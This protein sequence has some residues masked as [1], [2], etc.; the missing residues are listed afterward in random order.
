MALDT[1]SAKERE[2][3][4]EPCHEE[5]CRKSRNSAP[6]SRPDVTSLEDRT[7]PEQSPDRT[8]ELI[9]AAS[10]TVREIARVVARLEE[11]PTN[12]ALQAEYD[13]LQGVLG[14]SNDALS[15]ISRQAVESLKAEYGVDDEWL[16]A[17]DQAQRPALG[18]DYWSSTIQR[19]PTTAKLEEAVAYGYE[20]LKAVVDQ[21][22]L[23][24]QAAFRYRQRYDGSDS[25]DC[26]LHVVGRQRLLPPNA[27]ARPQR[28]AQMLLLCEDLLSNRDDIDLFEGPLLVSEAA[29][30]GACLPAIDHLGREAKAKFKSLPTETSRDVASIV[31]ELLVG[32]A[33]VEIGRTVEM[34]PASNRHKSPDFRIHDLPVPLVVEC[35]RRLGLNDYAEK[36]ARHVERLYSAAEELF[37]RC[38][39]LVEVIFNGEVS[40]VTEESFVKAVAPLCE[41]WDSEAE[42]VTSWGTIHV[43]RLPNVQEIPTTRVFS[44]VFLQEVF[45]WDHAESNWDGLLC[46]IAPT[47]SPVTD[48]VRCPRGLKW[49]CDA[50]KSL[51]KKARGLTSLWAD[52]VRQ[53]PAGE[54]GCVY[55]AYTESMRGAIADARTQHLLDTVQNKELYHR[56]SVRVPLT[57]ID[58]LYP[59]ALGNGGLEL[60]E[61]I[62]P[63]TLDGY[64][65]MLEDFPLQA[66]NVTP[67]E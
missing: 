9:Q 29:R 55:I 24:D 18:D 6:T 13:R 38:H 56:A 34:L 36:E 14:K 67:L 32:T 15:E 57:V 53:I 40:T 20:R 49:R 27:P 22:W 63:M 33:C 46:Q 45:Y 1:C 30:L 60:I 43:R 52:A 3:R 51:L 21:G 16:R 50:D 7:F 48:K 44:P 37:D 59:Q 2:L 5:A 11:D 17:F 62:V 41:S 47:F 23:R 25:S 35:K 42:T 28:F 19:V 65:F 8:D 64:D 10:A 4:R 61:S 54:M 58:R 26:R 39:P 66:F 31:F 12:T